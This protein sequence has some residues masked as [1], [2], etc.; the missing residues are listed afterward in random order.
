MHRYT[1]THTKHILMHTLKALSEVSINIK[2]HINW[3]NSIIYIN[4]LFYIMRSCK[5]Y[6]QHNITFK[7]I[8]H[9]FLG[10]NLVI[11]FTLFFLN[12]RLKFKMG[13]FLKQH[14]LVIWSRNRTDDIQVMGKHM[15][16]HT[17]STSHPSI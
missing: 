17:N 7:E 2:I 14:M 11:Y 13:S 8:A 15:V 1:Y 5:P 12:H 16:C 6:T 4:V 10:T 9:K 3:D